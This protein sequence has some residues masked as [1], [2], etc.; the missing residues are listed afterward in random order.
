M[1][2]EHAALAVLAYEP[3]SGY[4]LKKFFDQSVAHFWSVTQ[5]HVYK[6]LNDLEKKGWATA[7][8]IPQEGK[9][10]R[11][12]Y[13]ITAAGR[14]ELRRWLTTPLPPEAVRQAWLIQIFFAHDN[15]NAEITALLDA[16]IDVMRRRLDIY[17][18]DAQAAIDASAAEVGIERM[19]QLWQ[20]T[21]D[22]G[23][24]YYQFELAWHQDA[25]DRIR[26][27][28]PMPPPTP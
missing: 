24:A 27:L 18:R 17:R 21:L 10:N 7:T 11:K 14:T 3:V 8:L 5:S 1:P 20:L 2:L 9:P 12:E 19:R 16:R 25:L 4:D 13:D 23:I 22:Y 15:S 26:N 6:V 28:P